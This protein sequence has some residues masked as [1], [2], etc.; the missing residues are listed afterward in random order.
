M[1]PR[2]A[3]P[4]II[5]GAHAI[6]RRDD[7]LL[8]VRQETEWCAHPFWSLPGGTSEPG[9]LLIETL[10]REVREEAG[11]H[12]QEASVAW[13]MEEDRPYSGE[14]LLV[15]FFEA[16]SWSGELC[17]DDPDGKV[18]EGRFAPLAEALELL[19]GQADSKSPHTIEPLLAYF[20]D[21]SPRRPLWQ[22]RRLAPDAPAIEV[23]P[24]SALPIAPAAG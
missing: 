7:E 10:C 15:A 9:E 8:I 4:N 21:D 13:V 12:V 19:C 23:G 14:R 5:S 11:L 22:L 2:M 24:A 20:A 3:T 17:T 18:T 1:I 16:T 6:I